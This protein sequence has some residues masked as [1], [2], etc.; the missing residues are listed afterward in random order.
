M[1]IYSLFFGHPE[2]INISSIR[3][4][5]TAKN[6]QEIIQAI[7]TFDNVCTGNYE[8]FNISKESLL[9]LNH[10]IER[11]ENKFDPFIYNSWKVFLQKKTEIRINMYQL[12]KHITDLGFLGL[13]FGGRGFEMH[14]DSKYIPDDMTNI[15][16][17]N[18][19]N[20]LQTLV[21]DRVEDYPLSLHQL[22]LLLTR[23]KIKKVR[24]S[25]SF[26]KWLDYLWLYCSWRDNS[27]L[28][29]QTYKNKG[30]AINYYVDKIY[31]NLL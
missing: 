26:Y 25:A 15:L 30:Y 18:L 22:L 2:P 10:L 6:Y 19:F 14:R 4:I 11:K 17:F 13:M 8:E 23:T 27:S 31:I 5:E 9:I 7:S 12:G 21:L 29:I 24:M 20:N 16:N 28:L 3:I 1:F